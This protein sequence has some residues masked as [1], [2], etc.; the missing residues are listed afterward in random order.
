[1]KLFKNFSFFVF[2]C[3][4]K[5]TFSNDFK[6]L[7]IV[8]LQFIFTLNLNYRVPFQITPQMTLNRV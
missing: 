6:V 1:M 8:G 7:T 3:S 4:Y 5:L 2:L